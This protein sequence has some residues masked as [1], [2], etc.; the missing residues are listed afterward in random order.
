MGEFGVYKRKPRV[1][2]KITRKGIDIKDIFN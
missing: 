1:Y 2:D